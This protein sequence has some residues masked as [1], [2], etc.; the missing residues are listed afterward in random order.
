MNYDK[1]WIIWENIIKELHYKVGLQKRLDL[2]LGKECGWR[3]SRRKRKDEEAQR[4][5]PAPQKA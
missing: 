5:E 4:W 3:H 2:L 1:Q